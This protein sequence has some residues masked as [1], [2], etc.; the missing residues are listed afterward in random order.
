MLADP[1]G[2]DLDPD[3]T[4]YGSAT[5]FIF[6]HSL[7]PSVNVPGHKGL[8]ILSKMSAKPGIVIS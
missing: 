5:M 6:L 3:P 8:Q 2:V 7:L 1:G 4:G